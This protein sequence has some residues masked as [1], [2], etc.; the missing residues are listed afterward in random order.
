[1][2]EGDEGQLLMGCPEQMWALFI[3]TDQRAPFMCP[4]LGVKTLLLS[5][6]PSQLSIYRDV[7]RE[8]ARIDVRLV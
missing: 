7:S 4:R 5:Q 1:M 8:I 2:E 3:T 6:N